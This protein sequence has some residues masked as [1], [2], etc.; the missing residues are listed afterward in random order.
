MLSC[1]VV[2]TCDLACVC[3]F[4]FFF[5]QKTAYEMRISDWSSD[6]CSSDLNTVDP[7]D[8]ADRAQ[9]LCGRID[10]QRPNCERQRVCA[11]PVGSV[12]QSITRHQLPLLRVAVH[13]RAHV[14]AKGRR[15]PR[16]APDRTG[17]VLPPL[18]HSHVVPAVP[19]V[20]NY[21]TRREHIAPSRL[22]PHS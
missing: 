17:T 6:V 7:A 11:R 2:D 18:R 19:L 13:E 3:L 16:P 15:L 22:H 20:H 9:E 10:L 8:A 4:F 1:S 21:D 5:K 12:L 14:T